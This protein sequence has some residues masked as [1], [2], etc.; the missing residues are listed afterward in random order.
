MDSVAEQ[1]TFEAKVLVIKN[2]WK[3]CPPEQVCTVGENI[4]ATTKIR[5]NCGAINRNKG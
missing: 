1:E 2:S 5:N 3:N 4:I